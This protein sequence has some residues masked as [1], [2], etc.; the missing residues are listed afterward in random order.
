MSTEAGKYAELT[1][2]SNELS[3]LIARKGAGLTSR[4][5]NQQIEKLKRQYRKLYR[6]LF[7]K[8]EDE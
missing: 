7:G 4:A 6:G 2:L 8:K 1:A 3:R 5:E